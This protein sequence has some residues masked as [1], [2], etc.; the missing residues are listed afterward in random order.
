MSDVETIRERLPEGAKRLGTST[1]FYR[2]SAKGRDIYEAL[3]IKDARIP[4]VITY[5]LRRTVPVPSA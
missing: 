4:I 2:D 3:E 5:G 1:M